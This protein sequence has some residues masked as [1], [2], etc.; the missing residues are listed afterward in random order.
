MWFE[1]LE[2][3]DEIVED[4]HPIIEKLLEV[5]KE[6]EVGIP[7]VAIGDATLAGKS[8]LSAAL[9]SI[10]N[11]E[12]MFGGK[13]VLVVSDSE[14]ND[15]VHLF[16]HMNIEDV[17]P[18]QQL[19]MLAPEMPFEEGPDHSAERERKR[20]HQGCP[21]DAKVNSNY[22]PTHQPYLQNVRDTKPSTIFNYNFYVGFGS[23]ACTAII[24]IAWLVLLLTL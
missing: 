6:D 11:N 19:A 12:H 1:I 3:E 7:H 9:A 20:L 21:D 4:I 5:L 23:G 18:V 16:E 13:K 10:M 22:C 8:T 15:G 2:A 17:D 14:H 24:L